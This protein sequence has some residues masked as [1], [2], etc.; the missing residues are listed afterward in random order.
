MSYLICCLRSSSRSLSN[1]SLSNLWCSLSI[2]R[3]SCFWRSILSRSMRNFSLS[4]L[5]RNGFNLLFKRFIRKMVLLPLPP[6]SILP[7]TIASKAISGFSSK[8]LVF[9]N[10]L[11]HQIYII[12]LSVTLSYKSCCFVF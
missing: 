9:F 4:L 11:I 8:S 12:F 5:R 10:S 2:R 3:S 1:F 6:Q 7:I